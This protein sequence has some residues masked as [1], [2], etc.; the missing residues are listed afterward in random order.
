M[1][2]TCRKWNSHK[3]ERSWNVKRLRA[4][5]CRSLVFRIADCTRPLRLTQCQSM[6]ITNAFVSLQLDCLCAVQLCRNVDENYN[7]RSICPKSS[8]HAQRFRARLPSSFPVS[9]N[10]RALPYQLRH[11]GW[12]KPGPSHIYPCLPVCLVRI[13]SV[14]IVLSHLFVFSRKLKLLN[15][16]GTATALPGIVPPHRHL[17]S[18]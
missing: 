10:S 18:L 15:G 17:L 7:N 14:P 9:P 6:R 4:K 1:F 2:P 8:A 12:Y 5:L 16:S 11:G 3:T 13:H